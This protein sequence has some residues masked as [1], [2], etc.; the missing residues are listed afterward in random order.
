MGPHRG[1]ACLYGHTGL[2]K[3]Q[4]MDNEKRFIRCNI[5]GNLMGIINDGGVTPICCGEEMEL[6]QP[7][8]MDAAAEKHVPVGER[9]RGMVLARVGEVDHPMLEEHYIQWIAVQQNGRTQRVSLRP[10]ATPTATFEAQAGPLTLYAYCNLHG[11]WK[12]EV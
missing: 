9:R 5:C 8:T 4:K 11:L 2:G 3:G 10:G 1:A 6:L 7:N 12:A